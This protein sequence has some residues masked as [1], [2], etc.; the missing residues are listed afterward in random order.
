M[1]TGPSEASTFGNG[2]AVK[3]LQVLLISRSMPSAG[4]IWEPHMD[5]PVLGIWLEISDH[6]ALPSGLLYYPFSCR[7][8]SHL[9]PL[10]LGEAARPLRGASLL[11]VG[12]TEGQAQ[13]VEVVVAQFTQ[14]IRYAAAEVIAGE[15][16]LHQVGELAQ[17]GRDRS[18]QQVVLK[19][20]Q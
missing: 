8:A 15:G 10:P 12:R 9:T 5:S 1:S 16:Q 19:I 7:A 11:G 3:T 17:L 4:L 14:S 20:Q 2:S 18:T 6:P 13:L